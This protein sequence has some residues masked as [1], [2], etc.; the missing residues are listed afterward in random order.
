MNNKWEVLQAGCLLLA[1]R[2]EDATPSGENNPIRFI[3][4]DGKD[5]KIYYEDENGKTRTWVF[6]GS[7]Q[8]KAPQNQFV[9][10]FITAYNYLTFASLHYPASK[11]DLKFISSVIS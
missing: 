6:N 1:R 8:D 10:D 7:N 2:S 5:I 11:R 3:D 9:S 4:P